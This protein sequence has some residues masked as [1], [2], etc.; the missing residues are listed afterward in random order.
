MKSNAAFKIKFEKDW[1]QN[2]DI[3]EVGSFDYVQ[4]FK[5]IKTPSRL[6][7]FLKKFFRIITFGLYKPNYHYWVMP[8]SNEE[9]NKEFVDN[10]AKREKQYRD[11]SLYVPKIN[12][13]PFNITGGTI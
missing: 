8:Y 4:H 7:L 12:K 10:I 13:K 5:V 11:T 2:K 3:L 9:L 1:F 6:S